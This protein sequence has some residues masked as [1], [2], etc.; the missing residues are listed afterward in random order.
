MKKLKEWLKY[1]F[2]VCLK[3]F[4]FVKNKYKM[5]KN[6]LKLVKKCICVHVVYEYPPKR[7]IMENQAEDHLLLGFANDKQ[8]P[9]REKSS[10][11]LI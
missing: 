7:Y 3:W 10:C 8:N 1:G 5:S 2:I 9:Y 4:R 11:A 6:L